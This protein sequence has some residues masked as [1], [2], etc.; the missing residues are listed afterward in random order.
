MEIMARTR[1][2]VT[3]AAGFIG[4]HTT[5]QLLKAGH[6]VYGIDNLHTGRMGNI[7]DAI[8]AGLEFHQFDILDSHRLNRLV[9]K[10]RIEAIIHCAASVSVTESI[11]DPEV[12]FRLNVEG[13]YRVAEAARLNSVRRLIFA[14]SAAVYGDT[15]RMPVKEKSELNPISP[16]GAAKLASEY[17]LL[18]YA[19]TY[20]ITIRIQRY[21][22]VYGPRQDPSSQ[23][24][25]VISIFL[26]RLLAKQAVTIYGDGMQ[27]RDFIHVADVAKANVLAATRAK[28]STGLANICSGH[29][30][31]L[32]EIVELLHQLAPESAFPVR[33][34]PARVGDIRHSVG[35]ATAAF[36]SLGFKAKKTFTKA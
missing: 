14:S 8:K 18:S 30:T 31:S 4:S 16:Y 9:K 1:I 13:T 7:S 27:T 24:S 29:A 12:N 11:T 5:D 19:A 33:Y 23:Y 15:K 28:A 17:L 26:R 36:T 10:A 32:I 22:N 21:F 2:L 6:S 34:L 3:G 20:G 25:G 35:N